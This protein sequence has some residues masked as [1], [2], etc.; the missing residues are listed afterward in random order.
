[1]A[2]SLHIH[3]KMSRHPGTESG[4]CC[5]SGGIWRCAFSYDYRYT[6][7]DLR[8]KKDLEFTSRNLHHVRGGIYRW[9]SLTVTGGTICY[10]LGTKY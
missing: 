2:L 5:E 6:N 4:R 3:S 10:L 1:M 9:M 7:V 8:K